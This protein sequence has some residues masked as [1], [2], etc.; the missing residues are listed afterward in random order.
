ME[1]WIQPS[2]WLPGIPLFKLGLADEAPL[3]AWI[4]TGIFAAFSIFAGYYLWKNHLKD[5][6]RYIKAEAL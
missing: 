3:W 5:W 6:P 2:I 1:M 4:V